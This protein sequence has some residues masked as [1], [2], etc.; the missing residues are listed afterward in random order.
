MSSGI[1]EAVSVGKEAASFSKSIWHYILPQKTLIL[2]SASTVRTW[3]LT[4]KK[5]CWKNGTHV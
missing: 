5:S 3:N 2:T 1:Y 4:M